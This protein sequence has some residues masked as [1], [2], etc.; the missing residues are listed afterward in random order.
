MDDQNT[1]NVANA[2]R[3]SNFQM[4][5]NPEIKQK[6]ETVFAK[7]GLSLTDAVNVFI[8]QSINSEGLPFLVS[9]E[10]AEYLKA[11]VMKR[12]VSEIEKGWQS[13]KTVADRIQEDE[14]YRRLGVEK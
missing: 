5:I 3:T 9:K 2:P 7:Y 11:K 10:N 14:M 13:V 12:L 8:Q 1:T 4:R 6:V